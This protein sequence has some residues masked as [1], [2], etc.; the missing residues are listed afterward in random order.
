MGLLP[1]PPPP[2]PREDVL[3][4]P[5]L[6]LEV[7]ET[8]Q[9]PPIPDPPSAQQTPDEDQNKVRKQEAGQQLLQFQVPDSS[10]CLRRVNRRR[11]QRFQRP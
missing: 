4:G 8:P 5:D 9:R 11:F 2:A 1:E 7:R 10:L 3:S 6:A